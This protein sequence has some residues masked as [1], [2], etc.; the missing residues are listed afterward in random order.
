MSLSSRSARHILAARHGTRRMSPSSQPFDS[1]AADDDVVLSEFAHEILA[2]LRPPRAVDFFCHDL[3]DYDL[4][5]LR[6]ALI[7]PA[8]FA[9]RARKARDAAKAFGQA[10]RKPVV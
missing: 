9:R 4:V 3:D 8:A 2:Q 10:L 5:A 1:L 6:C 7:F